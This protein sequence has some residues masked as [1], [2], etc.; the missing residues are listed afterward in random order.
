MTV[1]EY[2][3]FDQLQHPLSCSVVGAGIVRH[4][5]DR[6]SNS[7]AKS[8]SIEAGARLADYRGEQEYIE[9]GDEADEAGVLLMGSNGAEAG[10]GD[11]PTSELHEFHL[12]K[13]TLPKDKVRIVGEVAIAVVFQ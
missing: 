13:D 9:T 8:S 4:C 6:M 3:T 10:T 12:M 11:A 2:K 5:C 1:T 7:R